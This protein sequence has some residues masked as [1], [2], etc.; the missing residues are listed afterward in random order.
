MIVEVRKD[1]VGQFVQLGGGFSVPSI[2][3]KNVITQISVNNG[4]TAVIG[5]IY[6]ETIRNDVDP[7]ARSSATSPCWA[8]SSSRPATASEK[9]EL[10]IFLTPRVVKETVT[11]V[12]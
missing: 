3:T 11:S 2:D 10:L 5:G 6:E 7:G 9:V 4:D 12:R 8:T 1:T